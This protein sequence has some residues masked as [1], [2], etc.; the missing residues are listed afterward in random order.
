M[1]LPNNN[2]SVT[3][4]DIIHAVLHVPTNQKLSVTL[5][6]VMLYAPTK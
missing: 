4:G 5:K 3:F 1:A 2:L 6:I